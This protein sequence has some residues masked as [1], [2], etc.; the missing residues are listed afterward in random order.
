LRRRE[1]RFRLPSSR[2]CDGDDLCRPSRIAQR[3]GTGLPHQ[4][5]SSR[6]AFAPPLS[7]QK[8]IGLRE[9]WGLHDKGCAAPSVQPLRVTPSR[10]SRLERR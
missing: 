7:A 9:T 3:R 10:R 4:C 6:G 1:A 8:P 2:R 5:H